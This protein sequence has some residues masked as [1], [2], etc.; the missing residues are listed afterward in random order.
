[1]PSASSARLILLGAILAAAVAAGAQRAPSNPLPVPQ[2]PNLLLGRVLDVRADTPISGAIVTL[3]GY[4]NDGKPVLG[5][6]QGAMTE[7]ATQGRH[8]LTTPD[9]YFVFRDLPAGRYTVAVRAL[10]YVNSDYP[11]HVIEVND[12]ER[13]S[14]VPVRLWKHAAVGGRVV[15]ERGDAVAGLHVNVLRR[16]AT[17]TGIIVESVGSGITDDRGIYR[18]A[19]L[20]PGEYVVGVLSTTTTMPVVVAGAMDPS[21]ANRDA[22]SAMSAELRP[23]GFFRTW[24]CPECWASSSDGHRFGEFVLQRLGPT[25]PPAPTGQALTFANV[26]YPGSS[27][28]EDATIVTVGA[29]ESRTGLD[30][31]VRFVPGVRVSG[32]VTGPDGPMKHMAVRLTPPGIDVND[33]DPSGIATAITDAQGM[34]TILAVAPGE[35]TLIAAWMQYDESTSAGRILS[36]AQPVVVGDSDLTG[37][38]LTLQPGVSVSGRVEFK[39]AAG[40]PTQRL[41]VNLQPIRA[42]SWR[43]LPGVVQPDGTFRSGGN[44]PGR[45]IVNIS[46]LPGWFRQSATL[47]SKPLLDEIVELGSSELT[48]LVITFGQATNGV[49]G[50]VTDASGD[51]DAFASVMVFPADSALWREGIVLHSR[52]TR[53]VK[54]TSKGAFELSALAPGEYYIAAVTARVLAS[55]QSPQF[56]ERLIAGATR[57]TLGAEGSRT[58][59]L[60]SITAAGR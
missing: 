31:P 55:M 2:G 40:R 34:L 57:I 26:L 10:G 15:D 39:G 50:T 44:A 20:T 29:G 1:M 32:V 53:T 60:R 24:G 48:D 16:T 22:W 33:F 9:G 18:V 11:P 8:T 58:V 6:P 3:I 17:G 19:G 21:A 41:S 25:L 43:T 12:N 7:H 35:Y 4:F 30:I 28:L 23:S 46:S 51:P 47:A 52:R 5:I 56:L 13:P 59:T 42:T 45:Y 14:V 38:T 49:S 27:R 36:A 37:L 54:A